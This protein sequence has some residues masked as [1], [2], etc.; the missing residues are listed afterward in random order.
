MSPHLSAPC[1]AASSSDLLPLAAVEKI[2]NCGTSYIVPDLEYV[3]VETLSDGRLR[4]IIDS[5]KKKHD[6]T[7]MKSQARDEFAQKMEGLKLAED[8]QAA[9][10][11]KT[12]A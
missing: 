1:P 3:T 11:Q 8:Q 6:L 12:S 7:A 4:I 2:N 9:E 5:D 10:A